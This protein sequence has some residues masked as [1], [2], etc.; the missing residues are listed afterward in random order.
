M[1]SGWQGY[2][3][4]PQEQPWLGIQSGAEFEVHERAGQREV[5]CS[6]LLLRCCP[7]VPVP[8]S[9]LSLTASTYAETV[10]DARRLSSSF[11]IAGSPCR[12]KREPFQK[13]VPA[14]LQ[15]H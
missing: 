15:A 12:T 3:M 13:F 1:A 2:A 8:V 9:S 10:L 14:V 11:S 5:A 6:N 7:T 4:Y